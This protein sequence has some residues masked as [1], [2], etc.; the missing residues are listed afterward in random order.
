MTFGE[1]QGL[2]GN[3]LNARI[4]FIDR[5][6]GKVTKHV[7]DTSYEDNDKSMRRLDILIKATQKPNGLFEH[8]HAYIVALHTGGDMGDPDRR[9]EAPFLYSQ[10]IRMMRRIYTTKL[11]VHSI[12]KALQ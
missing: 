9:V 6:Y 3:P 7:I 1:L 10:Q 2:C 4:T 12:L 5:C 8:V 11:K